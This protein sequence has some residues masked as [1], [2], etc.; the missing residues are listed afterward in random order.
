MQ[1]TAHTKPDS[2]TIEKIVRVLPNKR[3]VCKAQWGQRQVYAKFY[4]GIDAKRHTERDA[5]GISYLSEAGIATS[6]LLHKQTEKRPYILIYQAIEPGGTLE[7]VWPTLNKKSQLD[8]AKNLMRV[9]AKHHNANLLQTDMYLKNFLLQDDQIYTLDG[10]GIRQFPSLSTKQAISNLCVLL[11]KLDVIDLTA[12]LSQLIDIYRVSRVVGIELNIQAINQVINTH[13]TQAANQYADKKAFRQCTDVDVTRNRKQ[14]VAISSAFKCLN[15]PHDTQELDEIIA[16]QKRLKD[17][18]T[19]TVVLTNIND[20]GV[21]VKRYN[22]K[23]L[24][25]CFSRLFRKTRAAVSWANAH[26]LILLNIPT[27]KPIALIEHRFFVLRGK[28]YFL[29]EFVD[30]PDVAEFFKNEND[31]VIRAKA[32]KDITQLF[33]RL[34]LLNISHGD[35]KATN[36][37]MR[38]NTPLLIDLDSMKQHNNVESVKKAHVRDLKRFMQNWKA[39]PSLYNAFVKSFKVVYDDDSVLQAAQILK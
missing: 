19:C 36:I 22:I 10:D 31:K 20:F 39:T 25:H 34:Y 18:N 14:F 29:S 8:L 5:V 15:I 4:I 30:A 24:V 7:E 35:M 9:I 21:V 27:P 32:M 11:S 37:K 33:F 13:R 26:R 16:N 17:G 6:S 28:A 3:L 23:N 12:W 2:L 1:S 38:N